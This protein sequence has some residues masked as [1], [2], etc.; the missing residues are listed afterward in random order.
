MHDEINPNSIEEERI[1]TGEREVI[2]ERLPP[3]TLPYEDEQ[4]TTSGVQALQDDESSKRPTLSEKLLL[5]QVTYNISEVA[6]QHLLNLLLEENI[7]VPPTVFRL[8][9]A[10]TPND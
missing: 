7:N 1:P 5:F 10:Q 4:P 3:D 2:R 9:K 6:M 8:K